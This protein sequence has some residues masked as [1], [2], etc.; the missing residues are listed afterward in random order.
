MRAV[1][2]VYRTGPQ[3]W[4]GCSPATDRL[5]VLSAADLMERTPEPF[6]QLMRAVASD[7]PWAPGT[8]DDFVKR[9]TPPPHA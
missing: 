4:G 1:V 5:P 7:G 2:R 6:E 9:V 3:G 8:R